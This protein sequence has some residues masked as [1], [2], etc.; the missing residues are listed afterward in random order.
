MPTS[1]V[2]SNFSA[3]E[4]FASVSHLHKGWNEAHINF[5]KNMKNPIRVNLRYPYQVVRNQNV[6][7]F[8]Q[9]SGKLLK[10]EYFKDYAAADKVKHAIRVLHTGQALGL[11]GKII[12]FL[13]SLFSATLSVS[14]FLIWYQRKN[15]KPAQKRP[16]RAARNPVM[17]KNTPKRTPVMQPRAVQRV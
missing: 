12:M 13:A 7:E 2:I 5:Q 17:V 8:D 1:T 6:F 10:A 15:K 11:T 14:G 9:F 3:A 4:A 16:A